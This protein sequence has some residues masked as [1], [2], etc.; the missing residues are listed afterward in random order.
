VSKT[1]NIQYLSLQ[2]RRLQNRSNINNCIPF[3]PSTGEKVEFFGAELLPRCSPIFIYVT[4]GYWAD[5]SGEISAYTAAPMFDEGIVTA[6]VHYDRAHT[7]S[8]K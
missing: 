7:G 4:G 1:K 6:V 5:L 3:A 2:I 8:E